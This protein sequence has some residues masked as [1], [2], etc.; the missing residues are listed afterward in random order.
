[1]RVR[2]PFSALPI[3]SHKPFHSHAHPRHRLILDIASYS[4]SVKRISPRAHS[5]TATPIS[6]KPD[7]TNFSWRMHR[8]TRAST[9]HAHI[10]EGPEQQVHV[11]VFVLAQRLLIS[12]CGGCAVLRLAAEDDGLHAYRVDLHSSCNGGFEGL[13]LLV[14][15]AVCAVKAASKARSMAASCAAA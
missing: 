14:V 11:H 8:F 3:T 7:A 12:Y 6:T 4:S 2:S 1:M 9:S 10:V 15:A 5:M 13:S